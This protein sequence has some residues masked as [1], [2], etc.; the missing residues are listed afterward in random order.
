MCGS[1][2]CLRARRSVAPRV[3]ASRRSNVNGSGGGRARGACSTMGCLW[4]ASGGGKRLCAYASPLS[5]VRV[6]VRGP[7]WGPE[8]LKLWCARRNGPVS[9]PAL[10]VLGGVPSTNFRFCASCCT[11]FGTLVFFSACI[12]K[13]QRSPHANMAPAGERD[14]SVFRPRTGLGATAARCTAHGRFCAASVGRAWPAGALRQ[15]WVAGDCAKPAN[16][17]AS[18]PW[19]AIILALAQQQFLACSHRFACLCAR[20]P[21]VR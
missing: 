2:K 20:A 3:C 12:T 13:P 4:F 15:W 8:R 21:P 14:R 19:P 7:T 1:G 18:D 16:S 5:S 17:P 9:A 10:F 11:A 6:R